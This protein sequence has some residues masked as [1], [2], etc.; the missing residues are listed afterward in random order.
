MLT[1][2]KYRLLQNDWYEDVKECCEHKPGDDPGGSDCCYDVWKIQLDAVNRSYKEADEKAKQLQKQLDSAITLRDKYKMWFED[3]SKANDLSNYICQH[4]QVFAAQV[5]NICCTTDSVA[6]AIYILFCMIKDLYIRIDELKDEYETLIN[7]IR[8]L[9]RPELNGGIID[10]LLAYNKKLEAV[11]ATRDKIIELLIKAVKLAFEIHASICS[12]Y[13]L[14][15]I[16]LEWQMTLGCEIITNDVAH[17]KGKYK[18]TGDDDDWVLAETCQ[19]K[20]MLTFPLNS[21]QYYTELQDKK[22]YWDEQITKL[23]A[24]LLA[25]TKEKEVLLANKANLEKAIQEVDPKNKC[26]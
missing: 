19:L 5:D 17:S 15:R 1:I 12:R 26:K 22:T 10:C 13:G 18:P 21:D 24:D 9:N 3:L 4:L 7:C 16:I 11:I 14:Q 20:P 25:A 23:T 6:R 2:H 8:C